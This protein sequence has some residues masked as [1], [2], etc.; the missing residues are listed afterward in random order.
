MKD[1][2]SGVVLMFA[3]VSRKQWIAVKQTRLYSKAKIVLLNI[4]SFY[5][6][7]DF[8]DITTGHFILMGFLA[9]VF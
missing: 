1:L 9:T 7:L 5:L 6:G 2:A 8:C 3:A 4:Y